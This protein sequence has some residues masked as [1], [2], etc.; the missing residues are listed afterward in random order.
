[1]YVQ[2]PLSKVHVME[3]YLTYSPSLPWQ[4]FFTHLHGSVPWPG[5]PAEMTG[6]VIIKHTTRAPAADSDPAEGRATPQAVF[7]CMYTH[8]SACQISWVLL[9][10]CSVFVH[11]DRS[12]NRAPGVI[13]MTKLSHPILTISGNLANEANDVFLCFPDLNKNVKFNITLMFMV[14]LGCE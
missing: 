1:M 3:I 6:L 9:D 12:G 14:A 7:T 8:F 2:V 4:W 10:Q 5:H 11:M 13:K